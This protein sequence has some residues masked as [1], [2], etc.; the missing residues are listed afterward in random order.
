MRDKGKPYIP[1]PSFPD[2]LKISCANQPRLAGML[3]G[4]SL[5]GAC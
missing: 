2:W 1:I 5:Q 3:E 4:N